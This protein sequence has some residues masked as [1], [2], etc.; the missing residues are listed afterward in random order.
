MTVK[1]NGDIA[2]VRLPDIPPDELLA[3]MSDPRLL[4]HMPLLTSAWDR[5]DVAAFVATKEECWRRYG[6]GHWAILW[7]GEYV[8]WGGFQNEAG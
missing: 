7:N 3:H 8:G 5:Q 6:L 2:F 4:A 1:S